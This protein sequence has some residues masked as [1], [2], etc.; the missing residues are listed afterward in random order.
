VYGIEAINHHNGWAMAA[1]GALIVMFGLS[2]LSFVISQL[3]KVVAIIENWAK[4]KPQPVETKIEA[5]TA[6]QRFL[7]D[8]DELRK[9]YRPL[10][11][12]FGETFELARL[13]EIATDSGLPHVHLAIRSLREAGVLVPVGDGIF[14][15]Q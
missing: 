9:R 3:H 11:A 13:Y 8:I 5:D 15:W 10:T 6:Q 14:T 12:D 1:A 7:L 2:V 4:K